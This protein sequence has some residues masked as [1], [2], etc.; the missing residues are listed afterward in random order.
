MTDQIPDAVDSQETVPPVEGAPNPPSQEESGDGEQLEKRLHDTQAKVSEMGEQN[1]AL[2][3]KLEALEAQSNVGQQIA[4]ALK[5]KPQPGPTDEEIARRREAWKEKLQSDESGEAMLEL[6]ESI[7]HNVE[8]QANSRVAQAEK[9]LEEKLQALQSE[10]KTESLNSNAIYQSHKEE[11]DALAQEF[12]LDKSKAVQLYA[13]YVTPTADPADP[14]PSGVGGGRHA[15]P[16]P[17][18]QWSEEDKAKFKKWF[19]E[20]SDEQ[21]KEKGMA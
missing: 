3:A 1:A 9:A 16:A 13:K 8:Q 4:D 2:R 6:V 15:E 12:G 20:L 5:D 18:A 11:V 10:V 17:K 19:P 14:A 21:L 7:T